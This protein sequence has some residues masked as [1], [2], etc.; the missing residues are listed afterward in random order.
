MDYILIVPLA[1][2]PEELVMDLD[3]EELTLVELLE[4]ETALV[5]FMLSALLL[6]CCH[7]IVEVCEC[8][9]CSVLLESLNLFKYF[10]SFPVFQFIS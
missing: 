10:S 7:V 2:I 9:M 5:G 1:S 8:V 6:R 4:V 3:L